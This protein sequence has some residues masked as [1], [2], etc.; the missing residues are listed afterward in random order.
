MTFEKTDLVQYLSLA[1]LTELRYSIGQ[2]LLEV[3]QASENGVN[4]L[5]EGTLDEWCQ[6]LGDA[7]K[8][9]NGET[10]EAYCR[11]M[12]SG[13]DAFQYRFKIN[14]AQYLLRFKTVQTADGPIIYGVIQ[15]GVSSEGVAEVNFRRSSDKDPMLD[16]LNKSAITTYAKNRLEHP[17]LITYLVILDLDNFKMVNDTF[18]HMYGDEVLVTFA[19]IINNAIGQHGVVGR[20]GG[21]EILIV[22]K[23][24]P[25]K[26]TLRLYLRE[27]RMNLELTYKGKLNGISLTCSMGAAAYPTHASTYR[28][29]MELA[30]KMLYLAKEKGRNRYLIYTPEMHADYVKSNNR[31]EQNSVQPVKSYDKIGIMHY[32]LTDFLVNQN[33]SN[34]YVFD[35]LGNAFHLNEVLCL[36]NMGDIGF[37]WTSEGEKLSEEDMHLIDVFDPFFD[38]TDNNGLI[39]IDGLFEIQENCPELYQKLSARKIESALFYRLRH[40]GEPDGYMVFAKRHQRQ[41][42]SEYEVMSLAMVAKIFELSI[43]VDSR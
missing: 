29:T 14:D 2:D 42:W 32:L 34:D 38:R 17:E 16:M 18:G 6:Y 8:D 11:D 40:N 23:D 35:K 10:M 27:I 1:H 30:D 41:K 9:G 19:E 3:F 25:D 33:S 22:T 37:R 31:G 36:Y 5:F 15:T 28:E 21:D 4:V 12:R 13:R 43:A 24:I 7:R 26:S 20:I 39:V